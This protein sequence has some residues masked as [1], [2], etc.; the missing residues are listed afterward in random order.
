MWQKL[1][2]WWGGLPHTVQAVI[3][4][5]GGAAFGVL[6]NVVQQWA[7]GQQVC[8]VALGPC[9]KAYVISAVKAGVIAVAGL[10]IRSSYH[11]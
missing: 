9:V 4:A 7:S 1:V 3:V 8:A 5:F 11:K 2:A 10:Y 6:W